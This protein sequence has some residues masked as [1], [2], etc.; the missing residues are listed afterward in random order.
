MIPNF[1]LFGKEISPYML[2]ALAGVFVILY[3]TLKIAKKRGLDEIHMLY[4][5]LFSF[6]GVLLGGHLLYG[7]TN[8]KIIVY[9]FQ[10]LYEID[11]FSAFIERAA[12][13]FGGSVFYGGLIGAVIVSFIYLKRNKLSIGAYSDAAAPAIPLFHFFGRLGCFF[14]GC[15]YGVEWAHGFTYHYSLIGSANG[16]PRFPV[17]LVEAA[18]NLLLFL[19]LYGCLKKGMLKNKLL[20]VYFSVYP[21]Y[22]FLLEY[23]RGDAYR[24]F[25]GPFSTSQVVS[26]LLLLAAG[27]FWLYTAYKAR[28][29][30]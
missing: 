23:L 11:S 28:S 17:Q 24:G 1:N 15:C 12:L 3:F 13:I 4:M 5:T 18:C 19:L 22:R 25:W 27:T 14:S 7:L 2:A 20:A 16:V 8:L 21:V 29:A 9:T 26:L 6:I 10:N 30:K